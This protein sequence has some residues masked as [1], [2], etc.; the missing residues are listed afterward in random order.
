MGRKKLENTPTLSERANAWRKEHS[1]AFTI[2]LNNDTQM[3]VIN[4]LKAAPNKTEYIVKLIRQ[5][6]ERNGEKTY[7]KLY[8]KDLTDEMSDNDMIDLIFEDNSTLKARKSELLNDT[9][10]VKEYSC[11]GNKWT[12]YVKTR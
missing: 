5:D 6:M 12:I 8:L 1:T 2:K 7:S 10:Q 9:R 3:D 11:V 4:K